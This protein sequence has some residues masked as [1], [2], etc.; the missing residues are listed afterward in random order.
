MGDQENGTVVEVDYYMLL[1][2]SR[3]VRWPEVR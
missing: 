2:V 1:G 3:D